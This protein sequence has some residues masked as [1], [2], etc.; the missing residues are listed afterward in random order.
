MKKGY[1]LLYC[2]TTSC[3]VK[4]IE[5]YI[6]REEEESAGLETSIISKDLRCPECD[7][8]FSTSQ[9]DTSIHIGFFDRESGIT[10]HPREL[11]RF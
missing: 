4:S 6:R 3:Y 1:T 8:L 2:N 5:H 10:Y 9:A 7:E 11:K